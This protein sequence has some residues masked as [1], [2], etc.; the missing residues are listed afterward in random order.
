MR[1]ADERSHCSAGAAGNLTHGSI[2]CFAMT[3]ACYH[4]CDCGDALFV[5]ILGLEDLQKTSSAPPVCH[6]SVGRTFEFGR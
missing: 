1:A 2:I 4:T 3:D 6:I 5:Q